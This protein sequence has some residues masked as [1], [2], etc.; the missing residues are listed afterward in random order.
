[1]KSALLVAVA[2]SLGGVAAVG[3]ASALPLA[4]THFSGVVEQVAF[5]CG[6]G[7]RPNQWGEC[8]PKRRYAPPPPRFRDWDRGEHRGWDR[9]RHRGWDRGER[10]GWDDGRPRGLDGGGRR[11]RGDD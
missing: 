8:V 7:Y 1:M 5:G 10:R 6:P 4:P 3:S 11:W 2:L 9:G